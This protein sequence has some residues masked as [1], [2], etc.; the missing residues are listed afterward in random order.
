MKGNP[1]FTFS[2]SEMSRSLF[3]FSN[4][5]LL[6][7][8][9]II[10]YILYAS[11]QHAMSWTKL[12]LFWIGCGGVAFFLF[13]HILARM[14]GNWQGRPIRR[15]SLLHRASCAF[16]LITGIFAA[17]GFSY[18]TWQMWQSPALYWQPLEI[19]KISRDRFEIIFAFG[20]QRDRRALH[21]QE[22]RFINL[23]DNAPPNKPIRATLQIDS[24]RLSLQSEP[25]P[26]YG[27]ASASDHRLP[28]LEKQKIRAV[29]PAGEKT[30]VYQIR[31]VYR[32]N[33]K[34]FNDE[35]SF[36]PYLL[37]EPNEAQYIDFNGLAAHS[38]QPSYEAQS[39]FIY[40]IAQSH[41]PLALNALLELL[42]VRDPRVQN[43]VCEALAMLGDTRAVPALIE[44][45]KQTKNPQAVRALGELRSGASV[46]FLIHTLTKTPETHLR[47]EAA[48]ALG[49]IAILSPGKF[50]RITVTLSSILTSSPSEDA[51][52][53][54]EA[55]LALAQI[56]D[57]L[58]IPVI[59]KYARLN[60]S[61]AAL[62]NLLDVTSVAGDEW[63]LPL[64]GLWL[65]DWRYYNLD[66]DDLQLLLN[67]FV[68][69]SRRDMVQ[70]LLEAVQEETA[71]EVQAKIVHA[72]SLLT[73]NYFGSIDHPVF[74][75]A[76]DESNRRVIKKWQKWWKQAQ[77]DSVY[78][79][80][81]QLMN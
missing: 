27:F 30:E 8:T 19:N 54:R 78:L 13:Y 16:L 31:A 1:G 32:E 47:A 46:N 5:A 58:A 2:R 81:I 26:P 66:L 18:R 6:A 3:H 52:V 7:G 12:A 51:L 79:N 10:G 22:I 68:S 64:L 35:I 24:L 43:V 36:E 75:L 65:Q 45:T 41:N 40:A 61:G 15:Y 59:L 60:H 17:T 14:P 63:L 4:L 69:T 20:N 67:Y 37:F 42:E 34:K 33:G 48:E 71:P 53:Q 11:T 55:M 25:I 38:R 80:Q 76:T 44:L 49:H 39:R 73:S 29:F 77:Q 72:L 70:I 9:A 21:L 57:T 62:R 50:P 23:S 56:S 74:N 28:P